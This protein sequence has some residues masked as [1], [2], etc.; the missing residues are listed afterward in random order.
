[1]PQAFLRLSLT[2][3]L[4]LVLALAAS[5]TVR[6]QPTTNPAAAQSV[7]KTATGAVTPAEAQQ[8]LEL[9]Q[10]DKK[11]A[12]L[13]QTLQ[14]IAKSAPPGAATA[15]APPTAV[16]A[17]AA[18][19][20]G[21]AASSSSIPLTPH[22]LG[23]QLLRQGSG[24][25]RDL[26]REVGAT[27][28]AVTDF[29]LIWN[30]L[31]HSVS[32]PSA[33]DQLI[34]ALW[35]LA[36]VLGCALAVE[37]AA[38]RLLRRPLAALV[39]LAP[40]RPEDGPDG[41]GAIGEGGPTPAMPS[42][43]EARSALTHP[44]LRR[45]ID[46]LKLLP[47][48]LARLLLDLIPVLGFALVGNLVLGVIAGSADTTRLVILAVVN[49]YVI[50]RATMCVA[51]M[52]VSPEKRRLRL[53]HMS[54][55]TAAY[56][57]VWVRRIAVV[58]V[59]G[60][61]VAGV[62]LLLGLDPAAHD[63]LVK[64]VALIADLFLVIIVLQCRRSV[65]AAM[66]AREGARG[67]FAVSRNRLAD[68][69]HLIAIF[70]ILALWFVWAMEVQDG[71]MLILRY[72]LATIAVFV[73]ARLV[74]LASLG[75][76][77]RL[78]RISPDFAKR[79]PGLEA[80]ANRYYPLVRAT[81]SGV[82]AIV[83]ALALLQLWG[84]DA[85]EWFRQGAIG[86]RLV[87]AVVT[88]AVTM[89]IAVA[90]WEGTNAAMDRHLAR[91][92]RDATFAQSARLRT[93]LPML[94][95]GLLVTILLIVGLTA[96]NEIGVNIGPLLA[97]AGIVG[98][99]IGFGSQKLVQDLING[100]FLLLENTM[101][102]GDSVT[103]AGLS[104]TVEDLS[105]RTLRLRAGD[106][107][108]HLIPFS[109]VTTVT[110]M[111]RG[112]GNAAVSVNLDYGEDTDRVGEVLKQIALDMRKEPLFHSRMLSDLQ[113]WGVDK[114]D[115][116]TVTMVGQIVCTDGG[117]WEVQREFNRRLKIKF[118]ELGIKIATPTQT[119]QLRPMPG[120]EAEGEAS[121][122]ADN[123]DSGAARKDGVPKVEGTANPASAVPPATK[124]G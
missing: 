90:V 36:L 20:T 109:S 59:F 29:P 60:N 27:A 43:A 123:G 2:L 68:I 47:I 32:D 9:L 30:W 38:I 81:V 100:V 44:H 102:V 79:F 40:R 58:A 10:D 24:L 101:Q 108:I 42:M 112:I 86:G 48:A 56:I 104:G 67:I 23:A 22:S 19:Q 114:L 63:A 87:S 120:S 33:R 103:L 41:D 55:E 4:A 6:A 82:I 75:L 77:D 34:D 93:L 15:A 91:L 105:I 110:N 16:P 88:V 17:A 49:A 69:W 14:T 122:S 35:K 51:R 98:I 31:V 28:Q 74:T 96:L 113:L 92:A 62:A 84:V 80:R 111:N 1:M 107:S 11:R 97:G 12:Q 124:K 83:A 3:S 8:A 95:T 21:H 65:S 94:R 71:I 45:S 25:V 70:F 50:C 13:I 66:R 115:A 57:E 53:L 76:L 78:F 7:A 89:V 72:F 73:A 61:A 37:W 121:R 46:T 119:V 118:Q 85:L 64:L 18:T 5:M 54:D 26:S 116:S 117:R 106:G 52:L 99:A 39:R